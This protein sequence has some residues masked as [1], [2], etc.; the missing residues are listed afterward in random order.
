MAEEDAYLKKKNVKKKSLS[1]QRETDSHVSTKSI[2]MIL[3]KP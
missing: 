3:H 2:K 1:H